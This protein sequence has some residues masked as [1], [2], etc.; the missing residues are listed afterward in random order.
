MFKNYM[1]IKCL[2]IYILNV[3]IKIIL[4]LI[5]YILI[6]INVY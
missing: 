1:I 5:K 3:Y 2:K 4:Y 6:M